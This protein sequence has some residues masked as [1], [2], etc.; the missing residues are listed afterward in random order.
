LLCPPYPTGMEVG[1][2]FTRGRFVRNFYESLK[3]KSLYGR[4]RVCRRLR[5]WGPAHR[6]SGNRSPPQKH[7]P[8]IDGFSVEPLEGEPSSWLPQERRCFAEEPARRGG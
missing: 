5:A 1:G 7:R 8:R 2:I 6:P 3:A 4:L